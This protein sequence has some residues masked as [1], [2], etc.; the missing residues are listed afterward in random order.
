MTA[1]SFK[2]RLR[3]AV[4]PQSCH[5]FSV[6]KQKQK[7]TFNMWQYGCVHFYQRY[8]I[9][10]PL[11]LL[12]LSSS[13]WWERERKKACLKVVLI[14][15]FKLCRHFHHMFTSTV[16]WTR[17]NCVQWFIRTWSLRQYFLRQQRLTDLSKTNILLNFICPFVPEGEN[18]Y[19]AKIDT[20]SG[21]DWS[22]TG[23]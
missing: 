4:T 10:S 6:L 8:K 18:R 3:E 15:W 2:L 19:S 21:L 1:S 13:V 11:L 5:W 7:N 16:Q 17:K 14:P 22:K 12:F 9:Y 20:T 23:Q